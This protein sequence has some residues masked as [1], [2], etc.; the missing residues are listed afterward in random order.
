MILF[1]TSP[2]SP[3][4]SFWFQL[5]ITYNC[6]TVLLFT[7]YWRRLLKKKILRSVGISEGDLV[8]T[9]TKMRIYY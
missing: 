1:P 6:F 9:S 5:S 2:F 7:M 3:Y 4:M 8:L